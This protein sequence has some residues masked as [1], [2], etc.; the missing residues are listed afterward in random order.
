MPSAL[1]ICVSSS[2]HV[3][4]SAVRPRDNHMKAISWKIY[5]QSITKSGGNYSSNMYLKSSRDQWVKLYN[6]KPQQNITKREP[7]PYSCNFHYDDVIMARMAS[8]ITGLTIV[9]LIVYSGADQRK[10][11]SSASLAFVQGIHRGPVNSPH[12]WPVTGKMLPFHDVT[13]LVWTVTLEIGVDNDPFIPNNQYF[14]GW[15]PG[16]ARSQGISSHGFDR[17]IP[18]YPDLS[19]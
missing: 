9:Y 8:Q 15:W 13:M 12:K 18:E 16:D 4:L 11:Q 2:P 3:Y 10:H 6:T 5:K 14:C 1:L 7:F 17:T 19:T